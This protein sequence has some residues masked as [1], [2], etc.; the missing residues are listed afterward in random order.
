[1]VLYE[2]YKKKFNDKFLRKEEGWLGFSEV[3]QP[4]EQPYQSEE[5]HVH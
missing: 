5:N 3:N 1:M 4:E 2:E